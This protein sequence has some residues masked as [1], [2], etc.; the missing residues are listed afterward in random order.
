MAR[1]GT[2]QE[3]Q[4]AR[5]VSE[6]RGD[7]LEPDLRHLVDRDRQHMRRQPIAMTRQRVDQS[8]PWASS[9]SRTIGLSPPASR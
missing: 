4:G 6:S 7:R 9:C 1:P 8:A 3:P 5:A 2:Q